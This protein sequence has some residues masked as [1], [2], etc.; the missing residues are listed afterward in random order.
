VVLHGLLENSKV[1]DDEDRAA[2]NRDNALQL[3]PK[4]AR[5]PTVTRG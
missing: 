1:L 4:F 3:F 2:I 5:T